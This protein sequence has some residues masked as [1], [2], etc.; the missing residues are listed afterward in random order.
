MQRKLRGYMSPKYPEEG[1]TYDQYGRLL[2][3]KMKDLPRDTF[4]LT[5]PEYPYSVSVAEQG[6]PIESPLSDLRF[7]QFWTW[8]A[9]LRLETRYGS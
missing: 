4:Q 8:S 2:T 9:F 1:A 3:P 5:L 6:S 7:L